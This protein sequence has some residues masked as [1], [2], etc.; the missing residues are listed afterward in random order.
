MAGRRA[1]LSAQVLGPGVHPAAAEQTRGIQD[2]AAT[3]TSD[4]EKHRRD[5]YGSAAQRLLRDIPDANLTDEARTRKSELDRKFPPP[6]PGRLGPPSEG[7]S[8]ISFRSPIDIAAVRAH[9]RR[10]AL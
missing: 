9:E 8:D 7:V 5:R 2:R 4:F 6:A 10:P 1:G 3:H